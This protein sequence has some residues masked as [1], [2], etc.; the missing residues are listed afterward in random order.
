MCVSAEYRTRTCVLTSAEVSTHDMCVGAEGRRQEP[1]TC[2]LMQ[3]VA[4]TTCMLARK[5]AP[6]TCVSVQKVPPRTCVSEGF[7]TQNV[8]QCKR[9]H[10]EH[11]CRCRRCHKVCVCLLVECRT[12]MPCHPCCGERRPTDTTDYSPWSGRVAVP[13]F[14]C[15]LFM[16]ML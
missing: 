13:T 12:K 2:A 6:R 4:P 15:S 10:P 5:A 8:I 3:K 1:R 7:E 9:Q 11:A 14:C 16:L